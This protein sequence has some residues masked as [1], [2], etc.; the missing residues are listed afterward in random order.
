MNTP[1]I[2]ITGAAGG[3]GSA[4]ARRFAEH[5]CNLVL[6]DLSGEWP[7]S[8][9]SAWMDRPGVNVLVLSGDLADQPF[10]EHVIRR[11]HETFG[12]IDVLVNNAAWRTLQSLRNIEREVWQRTIDVCLTA[13]AFLIKH[14][15]SVM[16]QQGGGGVVINISSMM[17][18]RAAGNSPAYIAVKAGLEGLTREAAV[19]YGRSGIRVVCIRPGFIETGLSHDYEPDPSSAGLSQKLEGYIRDATP[20]GRGGSPEEVAEAVCWLCSPSASFITGTCLTIDGGFSA[21]LNSYP[22]KNLQ[23]PDEY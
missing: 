4:I 22:L 5:P 10:L 14:A 11:T 3:I 12:R 18:E 17:S 6:T 8:L 2:I 16:E 13:P 20:L 23:F 19:T 9:Q 15:A 21:N 1:T 7:A